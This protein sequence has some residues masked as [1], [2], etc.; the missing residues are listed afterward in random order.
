[1]VK[2]PSVAVR[3]AEPAEAGETRNKVFHRRVFNAARIN[4]SLWSYRLAY[5]G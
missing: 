5:L 4:H 1:M 2:E 3:D